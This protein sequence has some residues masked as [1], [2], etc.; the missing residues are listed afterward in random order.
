MTVKSAPQN[1]ERRKNIRRNWL[2]Y[3]TVWKNAWRSDRYPVDSGTSNRQRGGADVSPHASKTV[4]FDVVCFFVVGQSNDQKVAQQL[5]DE[6]RAFSDLRQLDVV[7]N[8]DRLTRKTLSLLHWSL[9]HDYDYLL[10]VDDDTMVLF[11]NLLPWLA[12]LPRKRLYAGHRNYDMS[13]IWCKKKAHKNCIH[14]SALPFLSGDKYPPFANGFGYVLSRDVV[15][16]VLPRAVAHLITFPG[17]PGN[18]DDAMVAV[19]ANETNIPLVPVKEVFLWSH[20]GN[21]CPRDYQLLIVGKA[22]Q[23]ALNRLAHNE[24][25]GLDICTGLPPP[26]SACLHCQSSILFP[27]LI[28][29]Q[30]L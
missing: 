16:A 23:Q 24:R 25:R 8:Y 3:C 26:S 1:T 11:S 20:S 21:G 12:T 2:N 4:T 22:P 19:L 5:D 15:R 27:L 13:I 29:Y 10:Q 18:A 6:Q 17:L 7:D 28:S 30:L 9:Q 14:K